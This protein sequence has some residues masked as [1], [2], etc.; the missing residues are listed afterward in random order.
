MS[1]WDRRTQ[2]QLFL[3]SKIQ[4]KMPCFEC[5][6]CSALSKIR[7]WWAQAGTIKTHELLLQRAV[8]PAWNMFSGSWDHASSSS[9]PTASYARPLERQ[10]QRRRHV[11]GL[12]GIQRSSVL[13]A[14]KF[15]IHFDLF[16]SAPRK[17]W[18]SNEALVRDSASARGFI[19]FYL[20]KS[21]GWLIF[22][23]LRLSWKM[24][25]VKKQ[26]GQ[27]VFLSWS[28]FLDGF[29]FFEDFISFFRDYFFLKLLIDGCISLIRLS[30]QHRGTQALFVS[31]DQFI[32]KEIFLNTETTTQYN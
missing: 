26:S 7:P 8:F 18:T 2:T 25:G 28:I 22:L 15:G 4:L 31:A 1:R 27:L 24:G 5:S 14:S 17:V 11:D 13:R 32:L 23:N 16:F 12:A 19:H 9:K 20:P 6:R 10:V 3:N 29:Y 30:S 21:W